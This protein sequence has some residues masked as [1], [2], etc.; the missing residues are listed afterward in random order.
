MKQSAEEDG[1]ARYWIT[2]TSE[3][4]AGKNS[5]RKACEKMRRD[6]GLSVH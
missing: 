6:W 1:S 4:R 5:R 2:S 3:E